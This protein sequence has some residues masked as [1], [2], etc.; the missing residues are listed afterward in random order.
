MSNETN[1]SPR[2]GAPVAALSPARAPEQPPGNLPLERTSFVGR[3]REVAEI[4]RL[5]SERRLLTLCGPG[6]AGKTRLALAVARRLV[7]GFEDGV[8][9]IELAPISDP[10][11]VPRA[12]ASALGVP[13]APELSPTEA[14][15]EHLEIREALLVLDNCEHLIEACA[16]LAD[17]L[18]GSCQN[19]RLLATSREPL[20]V[21]G[22][23]NFVVPSLSL[24]D[25]GRSPSTEELAGYEA[26]GLF[27]ERAGEADSGFALTEE[28]APAVARLCDK[29]DG[30]PLAIELAAAR[31]R[32]LTVEQILEK[33]ED[34][35]GLLTAGS[36]TAAARHRTLRATL[37]WS[38][39]LL[40]ETERA[41]F[42]RL[43]VF[44]GGWD[45]EAAEA[46]GAGDAVEAGLVLDPLSS[47]VDKSLVVTEAGTGG[48]LRYGM[49]E[50]VRQ[51]AR[52]KLREGRDEPEVRRRHAEHYLALAE[53]AEPEL[54]GPDQGLWLGR[55]R[56]E[57]A[58]LREAHSWSLEP[59]DG[60][61]ERAWLGLRL[62]AALWRF[63]SA[64]RFEEGKRWLQTAL[65]RD[66]VGLSAVRAKALNGLGYIL[67]FQQDYERAMGA[68]EEA[69]ALYKEVGDDSGAAFALANL[70]YA[71]LHG[72]YME[73]VPAFVR[74]AEA[75]MEDD[76]DG[77]T[78]AFLRMI[79]ATAAVGGGDLDSAVAQ[80]EEGLAL[81]RELGDLRNT[82]M[83]LFN[84][85][86]ID[87]MRR[88]LGRGETLLQEGARIVR[89]IGD[90]LGGLYFV[91]A[92]G[93]LSALRGMP[94]R[95]ARLWGAAEAQREQMGM[96]LSA[97]DLAASGYERDLAT[98]RSALD[99]AAFDEAWAEGRTM[100]PEQAIEY[101]LEEPRASREAAPAAQA[102]LTPR[103][104]E[105]L[106][107]VAQGMSN[108]EIAAA[109]VL[110]G[111][112]VHRHVTNALGK[113]G[114]SSRAAAV[115]RAA[116]LGL[117]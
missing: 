16:D 96:A 86:M 94:V 75:L 97:F 104:L 100:S 87:V 65:E 4:E 106:G 111:H 55:L 57:F 98:V 81:S 74:E 56:T 9:W 77:H 70:G 72:G 114:V 93:K 3:D 46:V 89:E 5:L 2:E 34:P 59:G 25:P 53:T 8:W 67:L 33:L 29:L 99:E 117:L 108:R 92:F 102:G 58:N 40:G 36:R 76:L 30:I 51:F 60:E 90:R 63:W 19:L 71:A 38:H 21:S 37:G 101:A 15:T 113:L 112:T 61:E 42:R 26:V 22:E 110:S 39:D 69:V 105:V 6:G 54:V 95:A 80:F 44:V 109:L 14:L 43:S 7:E 73:R 32:V 1:R 35:L 52:E 103:E 47:L 79:V 62:A 17:A 83:S 31:I 41:L 66:P 13:E 84:L 85:G 115:A 23:T 11:L 82:G 12:V 20:R 18:L 49:L 48:A 10:E 24:P 64:Q 107:L 45:L 28:N 50:P 68:L 27:V 78:R 91:W 116:Q 88:E